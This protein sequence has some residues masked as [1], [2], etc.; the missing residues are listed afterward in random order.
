MSNWVN[1]S[2][3]YHIYPLGFCGCPEYNDGK[4]EYRLEKVLEWIPHMKEMGINA[5]YFGPVFQSKNTAMIQ[6]ITI[7]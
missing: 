6:A 1:N 4:V 7:T 5:I 2:V 3:F